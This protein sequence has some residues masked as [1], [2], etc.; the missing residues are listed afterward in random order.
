MLNSRSELKTAGKPL[1]ATL[2]ETIQH[3][4]FSSFPNVLTVFKLLMITQ[5]TSASVDR[6]NSALEI[7]KSVLRSTMKEDRLNALL[8]LFVHKD[9][10]LYR[11]IMSIV[12]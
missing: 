11:K 8:L 7:V 12:F 9:I 2:G 6:S 5:V 1:P 10:K 3:T 4:T